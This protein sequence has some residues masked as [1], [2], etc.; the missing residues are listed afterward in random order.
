MRRKGWEKD[1]AGY[2]REF[3]P[4]IR[5]RI[6]PNPHD[7]GGWGSSSLAGLPGA[8][9]GTPEECAEKLE[10]RMCDWFGRQ[11]A[12]LARELERRER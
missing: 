7:S 10:R 1:G 11:S 9:G 6:Q 2:V 8:V 5:I 4:G 12:R 3:A